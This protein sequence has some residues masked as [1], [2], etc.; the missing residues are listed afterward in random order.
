VRAIRRGEPKSTLAGFD[1]GYEITEL[2]LLGNVAILAGGEFSWDRELGAS[3]RKDVNNLL[4][5]SYRKG[6]EVQSA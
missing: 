2:I 6:W 5:K 4:T 1:F 3:N